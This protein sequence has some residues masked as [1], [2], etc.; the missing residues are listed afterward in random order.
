MFLIIEIREFRLV[1]LKLYDLTFSRLQINF[2]KSFQF[3][4]RTG[5][6]RFQITH[7][8]LN[9]FCPRSIACIGYRDTNPEAFTLLHDFLIDLGFTIFKC[10]VAQ[11]VT[12]TEHRSYFL[13]KIAPTIAYKNIVFINLLVIQPR[14]NNR[15]IE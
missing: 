15:I 10:R 11:S 14:I 1:Y 13:V 5:Q 12:E 7:I 2:L 4:L 9:D 8:Q 6:T 3:F